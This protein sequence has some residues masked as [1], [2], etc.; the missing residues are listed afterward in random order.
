[1]PHSV[2]PLMPLLYWSFRMT[3]TLFWCSVFSTDEIGFDYTLDLGRGDTLGCN[4]YKDLNNHQKLMPRLS[5]PSNKR[6]P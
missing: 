2:L 5:A 3:L 6:P 1:M 4:L